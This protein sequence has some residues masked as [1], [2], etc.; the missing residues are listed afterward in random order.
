MD[1][2]LSLVLLIFVVQVCNGSIINKRQTPN[3][4][5]IDDDEDIMSAEDD[6][7]SDDCSNLT[8]RAR[9]AAQVFAETLTRDET[10][11][12]LKRAIE[13]I[14]KPKSKNP[15][16]PCRIDAEI[17]IQAKNTLRFFT[18]DPSIGLTNSSSQASSQHMAD[19]DYCPELFTI[20]NGRK[21]SDDTIRRI[22]D[23]HHNKHFSERAI[24]AQ[25]PWYRRQY[26]PRMEQYLTV[27]L[28]RNVY[29]DINDYV[30]RKVERA[31]T[32]LLPVHDYHL[33]QWGF[34]RADEL[35]ATEFK[36]SNTWLTRVKKLGN[37]VG[38]KV[39][40]YKSRSDI[41][42]SDAIQ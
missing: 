36:A 13:I 32:D 34:D 27:G 8:D 14:E 41:D 25:Y 35:N 39:T 40:K 38:R 15:K 26:I 10:L 11:K 20:A 7:D 18:G 21:I 37:I 9:Q 1:Y 23:L 16:R 12:M 22:I 3:P 4:E 17:D 24:K 30:L 5:P 19:D 28:R 33:R 29:D 42:R 2:K 6:E 31:F